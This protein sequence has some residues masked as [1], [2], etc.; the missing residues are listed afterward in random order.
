MTMATLLYK[1]FNWAMLIV[2]VTVTMME[3]MTECGQ[4]MVLET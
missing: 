4:T 3:S 1:A 2:S